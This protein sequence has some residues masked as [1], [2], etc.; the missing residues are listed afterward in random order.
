MNPN[1]V[2]ISVKAYPKTGTPSPKLS[3]IFGIHLKNSLTSWVPR[4]A[5]ND[6]QDLLIK[7]LCSSF[8]TLLSPKW[9]WSSLC[10]SIFESHWC[11]N[12]QFLN[13]FGFYQVFIEQPKS[14]P[15]VYLISIQTLGKESGRFLGKG[16]GVGS[17]RFYRIYGNW[18][19]YL[20][21]LLVSI[22]FPCLV[23]RT[24]RPP[25]GI[26]LSILKKQLLIS[27]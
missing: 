22:T 6:R 13:N 26:Q 25:L 18:C 8:I 1:L 24:P 3:Q 4:V 9:F 14:Y 17:T 10:F 21:T 11:F 20:N 12:L 23:T 7:T 19:M 16:W 15:G 27:L 5:R 2:N